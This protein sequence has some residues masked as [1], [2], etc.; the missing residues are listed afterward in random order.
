VCSVESR[1]QKVGV[2]PEVRGPILGHELL[3]WV[4]KFPSGSKSCG[5]GYENIF[6]GKWLNECERPLKWGLAMPPMRWWRG[7]LKN[8]LLPVLLGPRTLQG[9]ISI[10]MGVKGLVE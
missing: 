9:D 8:D 6:R 3:E 10:R 2:V 4:G 7:E 5:V 1:P